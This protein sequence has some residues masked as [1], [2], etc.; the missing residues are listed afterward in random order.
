MG[1]SAGGVFLPS[2]P[3]PST[4]QV[5]TNPS[6][7]GATETSPTITSP[8]ITGTTTIATGATIT[9]PA[10]VGAAITGTV[11]I[12]T[13][14]TITNPAIVGA[15]VTGVVTVASGATLTTPTVLFTAQKLT[16]AGTDATGA[17]AASAVVPAIIHI[18]GASGAG[19]NLPTGA[20]VPGAMYFVQN[21]NGTGVQKVYS[22]GTTI[23]G[24]TGTTAFS[25]DTTGTDKTW[26]TCTT[27]GAWF[28]GPI[29]T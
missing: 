22:I 12:A 29:T 13:G 1:S 7:S 10:I 9:N 6:I 17:T 14:A 16:G 21:I 25:M 15:V 28:T 18:T 20:C 5:L 2:D 11:T 23:N 27:A 24:T 19:I 26:F 8:T 3:P 4:G